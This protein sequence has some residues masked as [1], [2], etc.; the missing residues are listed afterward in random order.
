M[1]AAWALMGLLCLPVMPGDQ[2]SDQA[3][4]NASGPAPASARTA[5]TE[6][7]AARQID[8]LFRSHWDAVEVQPAQMTTDEEFV[9]RVYLD[10]A[11]R[12]PSVSEVR[13]FLSDASPDRRQQLVEKLLDGPAFVRHFTIRWRTTLI[14]EA[15]DDVRTRQLV[16]GFEAWLWTQFSAGTPWDQVVREIITVPLTATTPGVSQS[17]QP[18]QSASSPAAF[19]LLRDFKPEELATG[20]SRAFLGVRLDCAQCHDHPFDRW[21]Q[22]EFWSLA[23]FYSGLQQPAMAD[24][25]PQALIPSENNNSRSIVVPSTGRTVPAQFLTGHQPNWRPDDIPRQVLA[26]WITAP[27]NPWF[28]R[29]AANQVWALLMGQGIV[30]PVDDFSDA[31]PPSHPEVLQLLADQFVLHD[32]DLRFLIRTITATQVYQLS[33]LQ[34]HASQKEPADFARAALRGLTPEQLFDSLAE[35][36]GF[37]QP[38]RSENP[39]VIS[40]ET[41]RGRFLELFRST[42]ESP[43][44][45]ETTILQALAMMNGEFIN[46]ATGPDDSRTLRSIIEFPLMND[47]ERLDA[48]FLAALSRR[49]TASEHERCLAMLKTAPDKTAQ[50]VVFG[51]IFWVLLNSSEFLLNH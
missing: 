26:N 36:T 43:L 20:T 4:D 50:A 39:F 31:N 46:T 30:H 6:Q 11:G 33:S 16:P 19:F 21:K 1:T 35:A 42:G 9:R 15:F 3:R 38:Y 40:A 37:Y 8:L 44:R 18:L 17:P 41:P 24:Q 10:L 27:D 12:I 23:A 25:P 22:Q 47:E 2:N 7:Q 49:P 14:P 32:F 48:L 29:M 45:R 34:S 51:D 13:Q 28:A 5:L